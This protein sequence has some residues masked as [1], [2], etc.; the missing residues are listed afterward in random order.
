MA[1]PLQQAQ[2]AQDR[3]LD[4]EA[5]MVWMWLVNAG[6]Y[7]ADEEIAAGLRTVELPGVCRALGRLLANDM[8]RR[9][10]GEVPRYGVT[11][12]C[13]VPPG[14]SMFVLPATAGSAK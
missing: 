10:A 8:V 9:L 11:H 3:A 2:A 12:R 1:E 7:S 14:Y 13:A 4:H 5:L 6:G